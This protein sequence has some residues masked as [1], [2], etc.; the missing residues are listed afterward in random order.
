MRKTLDAD[1]PHASVL[2]LPHWKGALVSRSAKGKTTQVSG[3]TELGENHVIK[4]NRLSTPYW[5]RL[6]RFRNTFTGYLSSDGTDWKQIGT[7][8]IPMAVGLVGGATATHPTAKAC[9]KILDVKIPGGASELSQI[10]CA[11]GL[12]Q[13]LGALRALASEGIQRGHMGLHARNLAVQAGAKES[14]IDK[15][16]EMLKRSGTVRADVAE[17]FLAEIR[18]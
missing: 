15:V 6:I 18:E 1:S 3:M 8:E 2:L 4:K 16:A 14:E 10:I 12:C 17:K 13:N 5:V 11:V 9:V 7:I